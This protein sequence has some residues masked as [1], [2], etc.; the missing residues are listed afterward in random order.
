MVETGASAGFGRQ[1]LTR[2]LAAA[3]VLSLVL[4]AVSLFIEL[5]NIDDRMVESAL[6][7]SRLFAERHGKASA[8]AEGLKASLAAFLN[9]RRHVADGHFVKAEIYDP[10]AKVLAEVEDETS[11]WARRGAS[12]GHGMPIEGDVWYVKHLIGGTLFLQVVVRQPGLGFFE[13]V[14]E[15]SAERFRA[16]L[17]STAEHVL[18]VVITVFVTALALLPVVRGMTR[19]LE[20]ALR[21]AHDANEATRAKS[22]FLATM[23]HEL[24]TPLNGVMATLELMRE[25]PLDPEQKR[26]LGIAQ[27]SASGLLGVIGDVLDFSKIEAGRIDLEAI[28]FAPRRLVTDVA[29]ALEATAVAKGI[30]LKAEVEAD[31]PPA[32]VGDPARL[33]QVLLNLVGNA[34]KFTEQGGV[35]IR[36][37]APSRDASGVRLDFAVRDSGIGMTEAERDRLFRPFVQADGSTTR[38][39]GGTGLGLAISARLVERMGGRIAVESAPGAG[40]TFRFAIDAV[41]AASDAVA[42]VE[43]RTE[44]IQSRAAPTRDQA[45]AAG[46][47]IL[48]AEDNPTNRQ[49]LDLQLRRLGHVADF[50]GDGAA[51]VGRCADTDFALVLM[52][53]HMPGMDGITAAKAI[54]AREATIGGK[55]VPIIALTATALAEDRS[56]CLD[57]GMDAVLAKPI[58]MRDL[59]ETLARFAKPVSGAARPLDLDLLRET[60]GALDPWVIEA[61]LGLTASL[62]PDLETLSAALKRDDA[63]SAAEAA[64]S[65]KGAARSGG[66]AELGALFDRIE[67]AAKAGD[68]AEAGSARHELDGALARFEAAARE[69][70]AGG[71][72][73]G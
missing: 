72:V 31:V 39:F 16:I 4:A 57:A 51:A 38:R 70:K 25:T 8:D 11:P 50:A 30:T 71:H 18:V 5:E 68:M 46:A 21:E 2:F 62:R 29:A 44:T 26:L 53:L 35:I 58:S 41:V 40:T 19:G 32:V 7:E 45:L 27:A 15:V 60:V 20:R 17:W 49:V 61:V 10:S 56:R 22:A 3:T 63:T 28:P 55:R 33:K 65:A 43:D 48:V 23:S 47:L 6:A 14:Y 13:G 24:R 69:L 54:R 36:L 66:A 9:E 12:T 59:S 64:H 52:D 1:F 37:A 73:P 34:I 42:A 67:R